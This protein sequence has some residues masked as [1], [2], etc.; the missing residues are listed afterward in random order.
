MLDG[1]ACNVSGHI[2]VQDNDVEG[3][4]SCTRCGAQ[5]E[6]APPPAVDDDPGP[7]DAGAIVPEHRPWLEP[8]FT[9]PE[10]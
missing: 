8:P 6:Q 9:V 3:A 10:M 1:L 2:W 7:G 4:M 5:V